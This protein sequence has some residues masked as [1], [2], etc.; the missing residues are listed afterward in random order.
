MTTFPWR[1]AGTARPFTST[2]PPRSSSTPRAQQKHTPSYRKALDWDPADNDGSDET[3]RTDALPHISQS[4]VIDWAV[5][6]FEAFLADL[7]PDPA[8]GGLEVTLRESLYPETFVFELDVVDEELRPRR[9]D[10]EER[11]Y[12]PPGVMLHLMLREGTLSEGFPDEEGFLDEGFFD[13]NSLADHNLHSH[14]DFLDDV[15]RWTRL[16]NPAEV[17]LSSDDPEEA[18][19]RRPRKVLVDDGQTACFFKRCHSPL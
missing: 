10:R 7:A 15:R 14:E 5:Q 8:S 4:D 13:V 11:R 16:Y 6:P 2:S 12:R 17:V 3:A 9:V 18:L 1:S 19:F